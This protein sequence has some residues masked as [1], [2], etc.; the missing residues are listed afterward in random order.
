MR[1][2]DRVQDPDAEDNVVQLVLDPA[3]TVDLAALRPEWLV[4]PMRVLTAEARARAR[5]QSIAAQWMPEIQSRVRDYWVRPAGSSG[6]ISVLVNIRLAPG[7][8]VIP[9]SVTVVQSSGVPAFDASAKAAI[10]RASPLPV[11]DG[12]DFELFKDF[13]FRFK[14]D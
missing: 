13:N 7:G 6:D 10:Y 9:G 8:E 14:P 4:E 3:V 2:C 1:H 11:P 5:R 12:E